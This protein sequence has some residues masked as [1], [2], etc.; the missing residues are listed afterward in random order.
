MLPFTLACRH[1]SLLCFHTSEAWSPII[2][3]QISCNGFAP[4]H[5]DALGEFDS[6]RCNRLRC[7]TDHGE[8]SCSCSPRATAQTISFV[9]VSTYVQSRLSL[10]PQAG[11]G[12]VYTPL[13]ARKFPPA[14]LLFEDDHAY[15][16]YLYSLNW[17]LRLEAKAEESHPHQPR[18]ST[19]HVT[20]LP[21]TCVCSSEPKLRRY[22]F[23][24]MSEARVK[25]LK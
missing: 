12:T 6:S 16:L 4:P 20:S 22:G 21:K 17:H 5:L 15:R 1:P 10:P 8:A 18:A 3:M 2:R 25:A 13:F 9:L 11:R 7:G 24:S 19:Q 14:E 23:G